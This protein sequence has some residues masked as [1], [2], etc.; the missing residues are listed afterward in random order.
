MLVSFC[1]S[2]LRRQGWVQIFIRSHGT[3]FTFNQQRTRAANRREDN[4]IFSNQSSVSN[5]LEKIRCDGARLDGD[6]IIN[7][8]KKELKSCLTHVLIKPKLSL[9][10]V[11]WRFSC[12]SLSCS[13][14][15]ASIVNQ[16]CLVWRNVNKREITRL[17]HFFCQTLVCVK[18]CV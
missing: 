1:R 3:L 6:Q 15:T 11:L 14:A 18:A 7:E 8:D 2:W 13:H 5:I 17:L 10:I 4:F 16:T 9:E 12:N